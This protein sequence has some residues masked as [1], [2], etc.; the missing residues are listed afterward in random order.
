[1]RRSNFKFF[2]PACL[3]VIFAT[4]LVSGAEGITLITVDQLKEDLTKPDVVIIDVRAG[5]DWDSSHWKIK[6]A[7][8]QTP[9]EVKEWIAKYSKDQKIVL[10]CA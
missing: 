7:Q 2:L 9:S 4:S 5:H 10:Y 6:G 3:I 1:M 8:R